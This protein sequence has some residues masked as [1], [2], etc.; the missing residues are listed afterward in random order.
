MLCLFRVAQEALQN[1]L[2]YSRATELAVDISGTPGGLTLTISDN[3]AGFDVDAALGAGVGLRS[4]IERLQTVGGSL[5]VAS[6]PGA[7][8]R[9]VASV[10]LHALQPDPNAQ[11]A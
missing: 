5:E 1:A 8:T 6:R 4:M 3:G 7:G 9:V 10:P 11:P 2:K